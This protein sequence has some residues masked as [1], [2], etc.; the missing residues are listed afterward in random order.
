[1]IFVA[2]RGFLFEIQCKLVVFHFFTTYF[3]HP[4]S[5][6]YFEML[7][8][9]V[10]FNN[11]YYYLLKSNPEFKTCKNFWFSIA[12]LNP[13]WIGSKLDLDKDFLIDGRRSTIGW[14]PLGDWKESEIEG[15][16]HQ[17]NKN[18]WI[19][20]KWAYLRNT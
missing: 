10:C 3:L 18:W 5:Q 16:Q 13:G 4:R 8:D 19:R 11:S 1:M 17:K 9:F 7:D 12:K 2:W 20:H 15:A 14:L 6:D